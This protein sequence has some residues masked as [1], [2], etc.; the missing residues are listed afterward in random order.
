MGLTLG[1]GR[2]PGRGNGTLLEY[3]YLENSMGLESYS[4]W[5][6]KESDMTEHMHRAPET[7]SLNPL[8]FENSTD[9]CHYTWNVV[10]LPKVH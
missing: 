2:S 7:L 5:S 1:S 4:P 8:V 3:S 9:L 10:V 6:L